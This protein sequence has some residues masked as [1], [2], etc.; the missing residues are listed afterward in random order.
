VRAAP[1]ILATFTHRQPSL[2]RHERL[3]VRRSRSAPSRA[4]S[5]GVP[6]AHD[7]QADTTDHAGR[8]MART[9]L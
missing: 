5:L 1:A 8:I 4:V 9:Y 3:M 2:E 6:A 7:R